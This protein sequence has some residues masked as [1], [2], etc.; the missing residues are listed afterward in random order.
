MKIVVTGG[1]GFIGSHVVEHYCR[2]AR[3]KVVVLD[4]LRSGY[5]KNLISL[6]HEFIE[7]SVTDL[8]AVERC[9]DGAEYVFHLAALVSVPESMKEPKLTE[10]INVGGTLNILSAA[11]KYHVKKVVF[12]SSAAVYGTNPVVP[13]T[14]DMLPEPRSP[15]AVTKLAG[16]YYCN[17]Y[18][19]EYGLPVVAARFFNVFG[20]RQDPRS[21]YAAAIPIFTSKA[22]KNELITIYGD[23]EQTRDFV[24]VKDVVNA[25]TC[26]VANGNG[27]Y[28][29]GLGKGTSVNSLVKKIVELTNSQ[30]KIIYAEPRVGDVKFSVADITRL[31]NAGFK[32]NVAFEDGLSDTVKY[33]GLCV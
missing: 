27:V 31:K 13:K 14:E 7:A 3:N 18:A 32:S 10:D 15:Y 12:I 28:N 5:R 33:F 21:Q 8:T 16:E 4:N 22:V 24:Y 23:G 29:I 17:I 6:T 26:V 2:D 19:Q 20:P 11:V 25:L 1:A 30:S 9:I